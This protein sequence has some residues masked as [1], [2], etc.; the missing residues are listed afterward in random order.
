MGGDDDDGHVR[1]GGVDGP[2][3]LHAAGLGHDQVGHDDVRAVL[4]KLG[5]ALLAVH[6]HG[7]VEAVPAQQGGEHLAEVRL[8]VDDQNFR[9]GQGG[10]TIAARRGERQGKP[11]GARSWGF[12]GVKAPT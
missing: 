9:H 7:D 2:E 6:G 1:V 4:V 5:Q 12:K 10:A 3:H 8:V 11:G